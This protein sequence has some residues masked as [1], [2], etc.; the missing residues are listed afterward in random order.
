[1]ARNQV[2]VVLVLGLLTTTPARMS[3]V[4]S[5]AAIGLD[6]IPVAVRD[7]DRASATYRALG[8]ALKP[9][10]PHTNGIRNAHLK[11]PDG[12]G[13][14]LL[15]APKA[16]DALS[17][18]YVDLL[19][20][21]EGPA[22]VAFHARDT[23]RLHTALRDGGYAFRQEGETTLLQAPEFAFLFFVRDNRSPSDRPEHFAH[24]NR[25]TALNAVWVATEHGDALAQLLV[26]LGG[27]Q[28]RRQVLAPDRSE[29][30][31]VTLAAGEVVILPE[32]HQVVPRRPVIGASF[33]VPDL[34]RVRQILVPAQI[35]PWAGTGT[36]ERVVV[37]PTVAHGIWLE[38]R[39]GS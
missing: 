22:F 15:T 38:F 6:H 14:E 9:G 20:A 7:L 37:G 34:T 29:A 30:T 28:Q 13:I 11:F 36:G 33:L 5:P 17:A 24:P 4:Q 3:A 2:M 39:R 31:V 27:R 12:A 25:A 35:E 10:R 16:A 19:D 18:H 23:E 26:Q 1:M 8:F 32:Q 21:G